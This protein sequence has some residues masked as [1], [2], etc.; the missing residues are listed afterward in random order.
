M[1]HRFSWKILAPAALAAV[2]LLIAGYRWLPGLTADRGEKAPEVTVRLMSGA[3]VSLEELEGRVVLVNFW[4]TWC[5]PCRLEMPGFQRV[6][7]A[8]KDDGFTILGLSTD[9]VSD[10]QIA[11]FLKQRG[12][13]YMTARATRMAAEGFGSPNTLPTSFLIDAKGRIRRTVTGVYEETALLRD[14]DALLREAGREPTGEVEV[15]KRGAPKW[16]D[17]K[18]VGHAIGDPDAPVSVVEF[19]DYGCSY[20]QRFSQEIFPHLYGEYVER[21]AVRWIH[22]PFILGKFPNAEE[23]TATG[24]CMAEQGQAEFWKVHMALFRR[25]REW[26]SAGSD[27]LSLFRRYVADA[28][29]DEAAFEACYRSERPGGVVARAEELAMAAGVSATPT[30]FINGELFQGAV[31]VEEFRRALDAALAE[32]R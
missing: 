28:G 15:V 2:L 22:V 21:G 32:T 11:W 27:P 8:R 3:V 13:T 7:E 24:I 17:L 12:I 16:L 20:C 26:R 9:M 23:A 5:P 6:Y 30:F 19:S 18:D 4:A 10:E 25:Q 1:R 31:P 14:V 29:G